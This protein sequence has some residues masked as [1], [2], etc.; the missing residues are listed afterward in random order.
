MVMHDT[1]MTIVN[2]YT[3]LYSTKPTQNSLLVYVIYIAL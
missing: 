1:D 2:K 3:D